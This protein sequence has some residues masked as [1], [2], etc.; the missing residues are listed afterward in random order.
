MRVASS[1]IEQELEQNST[2]KRACNHVYTIL[3]E[4]KNERSRKNPPN[5]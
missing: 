4:A 3:A 2:S 1:M 5:V